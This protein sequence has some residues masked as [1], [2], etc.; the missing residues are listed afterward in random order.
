MLLHGLSRLELRL[1]SLYFGSYQDLAYVQH[2]FSDFRCDTVLIRYKD[3]F[4][5]RGCSKNQISCQACKP[6]LPK[7]KLDVIGVNVQQNSRFTVTLN[8]YK[9]YMSDY[10]H[11]IFTSS[12]EPY[13]LTMPHEFHIH[14]GCTVSIFDEAIPYEPFINFYTKIGAGH[15]GG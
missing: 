1:E 7:H 6:L 2:K 4:L 5:T 14:V 11:N 12:A 13:F 3:N 10:F 9:S 15:V 8:K